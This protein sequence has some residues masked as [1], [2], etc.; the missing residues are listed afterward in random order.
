MA[1]KFGKSKKRVRAPKELTRKQ[2]SRLEREE[3]MEKF[4]IWGVV[5]VTVTVVG[6]LAYGFI[7]EN[8]VKA[9]EPVAVVDDAVITTEEFQ[10]RV[11]FTRMQM[12]NELNYLLLQ[13][14]SLDPTDAE[15]QYYLEYIQNNI[16]DLEG[17]L[18]AEN[19]VTIGDQALEQLIQEELVRQEAERRGIVVTE[20]ELQREIE[21]Y[22]GYDRDPSTPTPE[23]TAAPPLTS[24][25][26]LTP[27]PPAEPLPTPTQMTRQEFERRYTDFQ[28]TLRSIGISEHLY[29]SWVEASL[30]IE[31]VREQMQ[32]E[33]PKT[34]EQV[35]LFYLMVDSEERANELVTRLDAGEDP[36]TLADELAEEE[37]ITGYG[38]ELS[39]FPK[40][41]LESR[42]GAELA[43]LAFSLEIG[44]HSQPVLS[45]D[46]TMYVIIKVLG[47]EVRELDET[48]LEQMANEAFQEW[49]EVQQGIA[50]ERR[51]YRD[52]IP[53]E[54]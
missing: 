34:A 39:W 9:R 3:R 45:Q 11:R 37:E 7:I 54:P 27:T 23:P 53:T 50:V 36:Q 33:L 51:T 29:R 26:V 14:Q 52:R 21:L 49:L 18:S 25:S 28:D 22:F 32:T 44:E 42:F 10:A 40:S 6:V 20:E 5:A 16:R 13:Q 43:E 48:V 15:A 17:Q 31:K 38:T 35:K 12:R 24:T 1:R 4:L 2:R 30:L 41:V 8:V 47:R 46:G 19:A